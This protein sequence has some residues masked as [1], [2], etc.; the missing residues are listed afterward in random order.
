M[1]QPPVSSDEAAWLASAVNSITDGIIITDAHGLTTW[2]NPGF[3]ELCGYTLA[4][5]RGKKPGTLLQ[6]PQ[7]DAAAVEHLRTAMHRQEPCAADLL[8]Y[9]KDGHQYWVALHITPLRD[10]SGTVARFVA[11]AHDITAR[12]TTE[13]Q[14]RH[15]IATLVQTLVA[16]PH[17]PDW[18]TTCAWCKRVRDEHGR[19]SPLDTYL[20]NHTGVKFTHGICPSCLAT[21]EER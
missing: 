17:L 16:A 11:V 6:G 15:Q 10:D 7:T 20:T 1:G 2:A 5:L 21:W 18:L 19:W 14:Q 9:H 13:E 3:T 4:E 8:N 12:K